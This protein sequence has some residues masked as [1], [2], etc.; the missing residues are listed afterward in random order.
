MPRLP[1][2]M[3]L[4]G[5]AFLLL[6]GLLWGFSKARELWQRER[7]LGQWQRLI[8]SLKTGVSFAARPLGDLIREDGSPFCR[9]AAASPLFSQNPQQAL[10]QAGNRLLPRQGDK[11]LYQGFAQGLGASDAAGQ[12]RHLELY[13]SLVGQGLLEVREERDKRSRLYICLG[14]FGGLTLCLLLL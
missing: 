8:E 6:G 10:L 12:L 2:M 4:L 14:L 11:A 7:L 9:E 13:A 1:D 3:K 5:S